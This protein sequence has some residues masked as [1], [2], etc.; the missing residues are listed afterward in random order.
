MRGVRRNRVKQPGTHNAQAA[1]KAITKGVRFRVV[2]EFGNGKRLW[3][4]AK[5]VKQN[6]FGEELSPLEKKL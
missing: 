1:G 3:Q 4:T 6:F 5:P 2:N